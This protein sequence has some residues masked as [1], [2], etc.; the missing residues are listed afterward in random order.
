MNRVAK[1]ILVAAAVLVLVPLIRAANPFQPSLPADPAPQTAPAP[2]PAPPPP[3][4]RIYDV[5]ELIEPCPDFPFYNSPPAQP[6]GYGLL[7]PEVGGGNGGNGGQLPQA[8][9]GPA[10]EE[11]AEDL[12]K[13]IESAVASDSWKDNG[14]SVGTLRESR[15]KLYV[16]QTLENH[17]LLH[18][19]LDELTKRAAE[20][21]RVEADWVWAPPATVAKLVK[22]AGGDPT[23]SALKEID[24]SALRALGPEIRQVHVEVMGRNGQTVHVASGRE[25]SL[26]SNLTPVVSTATAAFAPTI[27]VYAEGAGLQVRPFTNAARGTAQVTVYA[28][29]D[30]LTCP[31]KVSV[32]AVAGVAMEIAT[33]QPVAT[34]QPLTPANAIGNQAVPPLPGGSGQVMSKLDT[35][36]MR[37]QAS[38]MTVRLP[39]GK[40]VLVSA[41]T[42]DPTAAKPDNQ[43]ELLVILTVTMSEE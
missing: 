35:I 8:D 34:T 19:F 39:L 25:R 3:V 37:V 7:P 5:R 26:V 12:T 43:L 22:P 4:F 10:R 33:P 18:E 15:G 40:P 14:G 36:G 24:A 30:E 17:K 1:M 6:F 21:V 29:F 23:R 9:S 2:E 32:A 28:S 38:R 20:M 13:Q 27:S 11:M 31:R 16:E 42:W 41:G